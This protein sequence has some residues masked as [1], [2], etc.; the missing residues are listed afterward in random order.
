[1]SN[2]WCV[3]LEEETIFPR[4]IWCMFFG[5]PSKSGLWYSQSRTYVTMFAE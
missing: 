4:Q 2:S 1:M 5:E 3:C